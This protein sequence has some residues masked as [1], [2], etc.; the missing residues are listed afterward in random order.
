MTKLLTFGLDEGQTALLEA[1][2]L[3]L[4]IDATDCLTDLFAVYADLVVVGAQALSEE[5]AQTLADTWREI[6]P[7]EARV[8]IAGEAARLEAQLFDGIPQVSVIPEFFDEGFDRTLAVM[9]R[10]KETKRDAD[11][12]RRITNS[13]LILKLIGENPG[14]STDE[15]ARRTELSARTVRRYI[16]SLQAADVLIVRESRGWKLLMDPCELVWEKDR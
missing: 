9:R 16:R 13:I 10:V 8:I 3:E 5:E 11:I 14:V 4:Q 7:T 15:L 6:G 1:V 2:G 12:S